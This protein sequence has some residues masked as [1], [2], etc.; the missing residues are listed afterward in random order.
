MAPATAPAIWTSRQIS[1][2]DAGG[3]GGGGDAVLRLRDAIGAP[4]AAGDRDPDRERGETGTREHGHRDGSHEILLEKE[5]VGETLHG[6]P[7][8]VHDVA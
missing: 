1:V 7:D 2:Q 5:R 8:P 6:F 3:G 4:G